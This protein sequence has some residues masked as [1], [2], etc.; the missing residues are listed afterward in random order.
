MENHALY[1]QRLVEQ[2]GPTAAEYG[3]FNAWTVHMYDLIRNGQMSPSQLTA[4]RA[5]FGE[6]LSPVTMT[7]FVF[8]KP[9]GYAGDYEVID[10][11]Y[12]KYI[13]PDPNFAA[14]DRHV[15]SL[16]TTNAVRNRKT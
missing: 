10:R 14:W 3:E 9:H 13:S 12:Q 5:A 1:I 7:S 8:A 6:V 4:L 15:Q 16:P 2:G 11:I